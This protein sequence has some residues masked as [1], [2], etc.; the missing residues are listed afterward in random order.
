MTQQ[1]WLN[2]LE[3]D[4]TETVSNIGIHRNKSCDLFKYA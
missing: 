3:S 4:T 1:E 2:D